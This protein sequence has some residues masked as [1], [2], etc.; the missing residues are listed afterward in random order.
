MSEN[1]QRR[2]EEINN[3]L[4][5]EQLE[6][7]MK[8]QM[9]GMNRKQ[10]R[11]FEK[12]WNKK[13][14]EMQDNMK[15]QIDNYIK[16]HPE[17]ISINLQYLPEDTKVCIK[18]ELT[19]EVDAKAKEINTYSKNEVYYV[20]H[21][22]DENINK[23]TIVNLADENGNLISDRQWDINDLQLAEDIRGVVDD[24]VTQ[25]IESENEEVEN[26]IIENK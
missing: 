13:Y 4:V 26:N 20:K 3:Q 17:A 12:N 22:D 19:E 10:K 23:G 1:I 6:K 7:E 21:I 15:R 5:Q 2:E 14:K 9:S 24:T 16:D 25:V 8:Q 11:A 18:S